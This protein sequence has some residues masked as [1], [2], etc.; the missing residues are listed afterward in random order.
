MSIGFTSEGLDEMIE[1]IDSAFTRLQEK[2]NEYLLAVEEQYGTRFVLT[3]A[4]D[5][6]YREGSV[7]GKNEREREAHLRE[8]FPELHTRMHDADARVRSAE[9]AMKSSEIEAERLRLRVTALDI[10]MRA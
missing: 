7:V 10:A 2:T 8:I 5:G 6:A 3:M 9:R 4:I 1:A